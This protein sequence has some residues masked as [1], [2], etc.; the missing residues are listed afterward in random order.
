MKPQP[1]MRYII[2]LLLLNIGCAVRADITVDGFPSGE[3]YRLPA[4]DP[5]QN[6]KWLADY[7]K[8]AGQQDVAGF[9]Q[10]HTAAVKDL[11]AE[12]LAVRL[13]AIRECAA[14]GDPRCIPLIVAQIHST[15]RD[16]QIEAGAG[17]ERIVTG[18]VL[19]RRDPSVRDRV[20]IL[21]LR[22]GDVDLRPLEWVVVEML[23]S[24][25]PN[26]QAYGA[27]MA[28]CLNLRDLEP[29]LRATHGSRH[30]AVY[31]AVE[32]AF[33]QLHLA[34]QKRDGAKPGGLPLSQ[35]GGAS[36]GW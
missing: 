25:E 32:Q 31:H 2:A 30:P 13:R 4:G 28:G 36:P 6:A 27:G 7:S 10:D 1:A 9:A 5:Q 24:G 11:Q 23:R 18:C 29:I 17:L 35:S 20:E 16:L 8:F 19:Q 22:E 14:S 15:N 3:N 33:D 12:Q 26:L 21:P 34:Y